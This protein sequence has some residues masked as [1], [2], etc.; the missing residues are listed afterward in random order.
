MKIVKIIIVLIV[1]SVIFLSLRHTILPFIDK[2]L[3]SLL[4]NSITTGSNYKTKEECLRVGGDWGRAGLFPKEFCRI[5][6]KDFGNR[7]FAGVQC[8]AGSCLSE[9]RFRG[10]FPFG[11]GLC[12]KY[13]QVF[14]CTEEVHFGLKTSAICRD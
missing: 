5:P 14:G 8:E 2:T 11:L 4:R 9:F 1:V 3:S 10:G 12:P 6:M 7:C 13:T